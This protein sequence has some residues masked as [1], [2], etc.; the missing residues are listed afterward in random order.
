[1]SPTVLGDEMTAT[2]QW[3]GLPAILRADHRSVADIPTGLYLELMKRCLRNTI[4]NDD[5]D[6]ARAR[7]LR[8]EGPVWRGSADEILDEHRRPRHTMASFKRLDNVQFCVE[9]V[10]AKNIPGDLIETGVWRG[11]TTIFMRA[12]LAAYGVRDRTVWVA[13]SFEGLP[14][15]NADQY[16]ADRGFDLTSIKELSVSLEE[17]TANFARYGLLDEPVRFLKGWFRDTLPHAPIASLAVLRLDG[18]LYE[19]TMDALVHLYPKLSA[20]G[21]VIIDDYWSWAPCRQAV[22]DYRGTHGITDRIQPVDWGS[23]YWQRT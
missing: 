13:D 12:I 4:Y 10:L 17:V 5:G 8:D 11:G 22:S 1:M 6:P 2:M 21:Y 3:D 20:G 9:E 23:A 16:P 15:P 18:D 7:E 14:P 19:S